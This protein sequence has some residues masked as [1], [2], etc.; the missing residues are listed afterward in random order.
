MAQ[1]GVALHRCMLIE[2]IENSFTTTIAILCDALEGKDLYTAEHA[3]GVA[4]L[5]AATAHEMGINE[6]QHRTLR[7]CA[8]MHD[9][10]KL[11]VRAALL[12]NPGALTPAEYEEVKQ[13]SKIGA[14]LLRRM[15]HLSEV[16]PLVRAVHERWDGAGYPDG[17]AGPDIPIESRIVAVCDAWHAMTFDRPYRRARSQDEAVAELNRCAGHQFDPEVVAGFIRA[18]HAVEV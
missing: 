7:H 6:A 4:Q 12:D 10:G 3:Q 15:P 13:H 5:A 18:L 11:G 16:A 14:A 1:C 17:L 8:L 2:E 9:I